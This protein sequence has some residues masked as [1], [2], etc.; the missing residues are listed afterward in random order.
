MKQL[1]DEIQQR[2]L[3][4]FFQ[5]TFKSSESLATWWNYQ[6]VILFGM[7]AKFTNAA[8]TDWPHWQQI[9]DE[10]QV[11]MQRYQ[12]FKKWINQTLAQ[13]KYVKLSDHEIILEI[14]LD[15]SCVK[16]TYLQK[17]A[18]LW[19]DKCEICLESTFTVSKREDEESKQHSDHAE[20][21]KYERFTILFKEFMYYI[22]HNNN[23]HT[24]RCKD[25]MINLLKEDHKNR[26]TDYENVDFN[27]QRE[28]IHGILN[29]DQ[30]LK[31][32]WKLF[33]G[34]DENTGFIPLHFLNTVLHVVSDYNYNQLKTASKIWNTPNYRRN[35]NKNNYN[36]N[37]NNNNNNNYNINYNI[38]NN[39]NNDMKDNNNYTIKN[40]NNNDYNDFDITSYEDQNNDF[41][42]TNDIDCKQNDENEDEESADD[43]NKDDEKEDDADKIP[44]VSCLET[45]PKWQGKLEY[46]PKIKIHSKTRMRWFE[47]KCVAIIRRKSFIKLK[48][49]FQTGID[50]QNK[51]LYET[52]TIK[53]DSKRV[54]PRVYDDIEWEINDKIG[55]FSISADGFVMATVV[56]NDIEVEQLKGMLLQYRVNELIEYRTY[57]CLPYEWRIK[58]MQT[59]VEELQLNEMPQEMLNTVGKS[60]KSFKIIYDDYKEY[61][62]T[63]FKNIGDPYE[64]NNIIRSIN[65]WLLQQNYKHQTNV[66][67]LKEMQI[68][69]HFFGLFMHLFK[70]YEYKLNDNGYY[71]FFKITERN[72]VRFNVKIHPAG[73]DLESITIVKCYHTKILDLMNCLKLML[74]CM[75]LQQ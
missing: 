31:K 3:G 49:Q 25:Q 71:L 70:Y 4:E 12:A 36:V 6:H 33:N 72:G 10:L 67:E 40:N 45:I 57:K 47:G 38:Q 14:P 61:I 17:N 27:N 13:Q 44:D 46:W 59:G 5:C 32:F 1:C 51:D 23:K 37:N 69:E 15:F 28:A 30:D 18:P 64:I 75:I 8:F 19:M 58:E 35:K 68:N 54:Q 22:I 9:K 2:K 41:N 65:G 73:R 11:S 60:G 20:S 29:K 21:D 26:E 24:E 74:Y 63:Y 50:H 66:E 56:K 52:K 48:V 62:Q 16:C 34:K 7:I 39:N 55:F 43:E 42:N 53:Q